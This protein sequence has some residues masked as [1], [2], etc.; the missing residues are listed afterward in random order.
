M[1]SWSLGRLGRYSAA[2]RFMSWGGKKRGGRVSLLTRQYYEIR[3]NLRRSCVS[4]KTGKY[5]ERRGI[6]QRSVE[7]R[8][9]SEN[10]D[11]NPNQVQ[12][13]SG[14]NRYVEKLRVQA[15]TMF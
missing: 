4:F 5:Y 12:N 11:R 14:D 13:P 7:A 9:D 2:S 8:E 1:L 3:G 15:T 10:Y 6:V